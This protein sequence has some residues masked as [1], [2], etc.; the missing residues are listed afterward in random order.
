MQGEEIGKRGWMA[1][2]KGRER[3]GEVKREWGVG[4]ESRHTVY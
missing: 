3:D 4:R 1:E 2:Q